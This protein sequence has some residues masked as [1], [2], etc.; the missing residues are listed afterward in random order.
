M[1]A[2]EYLS[3]LIANI[4]RQHSAEKL[5]QLMPFHPEMVEKFQLQK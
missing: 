5:N 4:T 1:N 2:Y 3:F